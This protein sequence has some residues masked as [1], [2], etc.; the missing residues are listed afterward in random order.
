MDK[1]EEKA[2]ESRLIDYN[3]AEVPHLLQGIIDGALK[4]QDAQTASIKDAECQARVE[5]I[6]EEIEEHCQ[7]FDKDGNPIIYLNYKRAD[8][9]R[10]EINWWQA[11]K[12]REQ[13]EV[14]DELGT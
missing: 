4:D 6:F 11:L 12:K 2:D 10:K 7:T 1:I 13:K 8:G 14:K 5:R 9:N 3:R